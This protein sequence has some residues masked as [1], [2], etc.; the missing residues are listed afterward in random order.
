MP[1]AAGLQRVCDDDSVLLGLGRYHL[2]VGPFASVN[3]VVMEV[4]GQQAALRDGHVEIGQQ[5]GRYLLPVQALQQFRC[6]G[7]GAGA[8]GLA[9]SGVCLIQAAGCTARLPRRA[10]CGGHVAVHGVEDAEQRL[11]QLGA[12]LAPIEAIVAEVTF[13]IL[14]PEAATEFTKRTCAEDGIVGRLEILVDDEPPVVHQ[15]VAMDRIEDVWVHIVGIR[16]DQ[17]ATGQDFLGKARWARAEILHH[18]ATDFGRL[19]GQACLRD[20]RV[21]L[22]LAKVVLARRFVLQDQCLEAQ[23]VVLLDPEQ[24]KAFVNLHV[25]APQDLVDLRLDLVTLEER[26]H[27]QLVRC[28]GEPRR[29]HK[30]DFRRGNFAHEKTLDHAIG[31]Q[32]A[33]VHHRVRQRI[34][35]QRLDQG[36][37]FNEEITDGRV[38]GGHAAINAAVTVCYM[39]HPPRADAQGV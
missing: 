8:D 9:R 25:H 5:L 11:R 16:G 34:P 10:P 1:L 23:A 14:A 18:S 31:V 19:A 32:R 30:D 26:I 21:G 3:P 24:V 20:G 7:S 37:A 38:R 17:D 15:A 36:A 27:G 6:S 28:V 35:N 13:G 33:A 4:A 22:R 39:L 2:R 29:Q 12:H